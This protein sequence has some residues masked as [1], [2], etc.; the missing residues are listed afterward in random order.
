MVPLLRLNIPFGA[1][2]LGK[3]IQKLAGSPVDGPSAR[4]Q[5]RIGRRNFKHPLRGGN[6]FPGQCQNCP[7]LQP[8]FARDP[9]QEKMWGGKVVLCGGLD[10]SKDSGQPSAASDLPYIIVEPLQASKGTVRLIENRNRPL[11]AAPPDSK[12]SQE[13]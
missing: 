6:L 8:F 10:F 5:P 9:Y 1:A 3:E 2:S 4:F 11:H 13:V 7:R 12:S